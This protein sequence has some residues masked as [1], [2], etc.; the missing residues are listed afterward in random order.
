M[1]TLDTRRNVKNVCFPFSVKNF[2]LQ[3]TLSLQTTHTFVH[4]LRSSILFW[5]KSPSAPALWLQV[6]GQLHTHENPRREKRHQNEQETHRDQQDA[7]QLGLAGYMHLVHNDEPNSTDCEQKAARQ[8][9]HDV[10]AVDA[11]R[12]ESDG[13]RVAVFVGCGADAGRLDNHVIDDS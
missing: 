6:A 4:F 1:D 11:V 10:L 8:P 2:L 12:H 7:I 5:S 9:F 3:I 13:P